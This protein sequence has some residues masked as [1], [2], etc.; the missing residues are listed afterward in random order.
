MKRLRRILHPSDFSSASRAAFTKALEMAQ[1]NRAELILAHVIS[2]VV[3]TMNGEYISPRIIEDV[4]RATRADAERGL[5]A[6]AKRAKRPGVRVSMRL[7]E[8][9]PAGGIVKL[10][11]A[12]RADLIVVGTHGRTGLAKLFLGSVAERVVGTAPCPVLTVRGTSR[13]R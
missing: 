7:A 3:P 8:G 11:R 1:A 10:A 12:T 4:M 5:A 9:T 6:L 13:S 2:P